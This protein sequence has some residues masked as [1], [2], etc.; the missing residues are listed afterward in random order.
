MRL[1]S[2]PLWL[3]AALPAAASP[4]LFVT[5]LDLTALPPAVTPHVVADPQGGWLLSLQT[6]EDKGCSTLMIAG[7][8]DDGR[9]AAPKVVSR[10]CE[11]FV[12]WADFPGIVV[13]DNGDWLSWW[14]QESGPGTY[15]YDIHVVRSTDRGASWSEALVPHDDGTETEHGFV[16]AAPAGDDRVRLVWLD[17]RHTGGGGHEGHHAE[18]PMSLRSAVLGRDGLT[19]EAEIDALTCSCCGT[20]LARLADGSHLTVYRDRD[21]AEIRDIAIARV[22]AKGWQAAGLVHEDGWRTPACPVNGPA[23]A[24]HGATALIAWTTLVD[25]ERM[26]VRIRDRARAKP[27]RALEEGPGVLGRVDVARI[28]GHWLVSWL[29]AGAERQTVLRVALL[30][31]GLEEIVRS[32]IATIAPGRNTG[33]PRL[34]A[35]GEEAVL[36]WTEVIE[37]SGERVRTRVAG[38]RLSAS[39]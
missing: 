13:A 3:L 39:R 30:D 37:E 23:L 38:V 33:F 11:R 32:D 19:D 17:G 14:L 5:P 35:Q 7:I 9:A 4:R 27:M 22:D 24:A 20:D 10:G 28:G 16:A 15:A 8:D 1:P 18:G 6:R 26:A 12:N 36:V 21:D 25:G 34:A 2:L 29:G 31:A